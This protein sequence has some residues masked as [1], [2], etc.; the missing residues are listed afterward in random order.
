MGPIDYIGGGLGAPIVSMSSLLQRTPCFRGGVGD[1]ELGS[2]ADR[3]ERSGVGT[4]RSCLDV[5][6]M[7]TV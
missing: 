6:R 2:W 3:Y 5:D 4:H 7:K 1:E